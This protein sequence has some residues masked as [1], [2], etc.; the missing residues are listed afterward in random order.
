MRWPETRCFRFKIP[1]TRKC[2]TRRYKWPGFRC[3]W[4]AVG[5]RW[6]CAVTWLQ[7]LCYWRSSTTQWCAPCCCVARCATLPTQCW[8]EWRSPTRSLV[9]CL[10]RTTCAS[11]RPDDTAT[12][13]RTTGA[14]PTRRWL[15]TC[16]PPV[17]QRPYGSPLPSRFTGRLLWF[18]HRSRPISYLV[19]IFNHGYVIYLSASVLPVPSSRSRL[20]LVNN[21][22]LCCILWII[23]NC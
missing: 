12:G 3:C 7:P 19:Q 22:V 9:C 1:V 20:T 21:S 13:F 5:W 15:I 14:W 17:T 18:T 6:Q 8:S 16:Q 10:C 4:T 2:R 23:I 11:T